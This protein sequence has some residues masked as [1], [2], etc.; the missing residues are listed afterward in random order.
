MTEPS[1]RTCPFYPHNRLGKQGF[2]GMCLCMIAGPRPVGILYGSLLDSGNLILSP[3]AFLSQILWMGHLVLDVLLRWFTETA[4]YSDTC[5]GT[6]MFGI[7]WYLTMSPQNICQ[8]QPVYFFKLLL[9]ERSKWSTWV[10]DMSQTD[11]FLWNW[12]FV[13]LCLFIVTIMP[14]IIEDHLFKMFCRMVVPMPRKTRKGETVIIEWPGEANINP[15]LPYEWT[16]SH[17]NSVLKLPYLMFSD[18]YLSM[19]WK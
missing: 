5:S 13:C 19:Q 1:S 10:N 8:G 15:Q 6:F 2:S 11:L 14:S 18:Q 3:L 4:S 17:R 9:V 12:S 16:V 7:P